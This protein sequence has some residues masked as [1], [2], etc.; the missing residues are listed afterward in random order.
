MKTLI[1]F[2]F[3]FSITTFSTPSR[4]IYIP[5]TDYYKLATPHL[6]IDNYFEV[7]EKGS[8][9]T[10]IGLGMGFLPFEYL[11][12]E[13]GI[14]YRA[15]EDSPIFLNGKFVI[16]QTKFPSF[17]L[18]LFNAGVSSDTFKPVYYILISQNFSSYGRFL[19]G[20][21]VGDKD[22]LV[23]SEGDQDNKGLLLGY[24]RYFNEVSKNLYFGIDYFM[25]ENMFSSLNFGF[26]WK[27][28]QN[29][30]L[31]ISYNVMLQ[32]NSKNRI[33]FQVD[34]DSF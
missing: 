23:D 34:I 26:G 32:E 30:L 9:L 28:A 17:A 12:F 24:D 20:F 7:K 14:D 15:N 11:K 33:T 16:P 2:L 22:Y 4:M 5:S 18:G 29:V 3:I 25:G 8:A 6:D 31:K 19:V 10:E 13:G 27:F 1:F 21:Y